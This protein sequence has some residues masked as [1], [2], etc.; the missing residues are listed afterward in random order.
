MRKSPRKR[1]RCY[2]AGTF[3]DGSPYPYF[4]AEYRQRPQ[5]RHLYSPSY[6]I[7]LPHVLVNRIPCPACVAAGRCGKNKSPICLRVLGWPKSPCR[8]VD[9]EKNIYIVGHRYRCVQ[10]DCKKTYQS[11][12]PSLL[13][14]LPPAL[15]LQ[16][17]HRLT[18]RGGLTDRVATLMRS[19]FQQGT[20]P[21]PFAEMLQTFHYRHYD[22]LHL[23]Y[24]QM[25]KIRKES[26]IFKLMG[27]LPA[28]GLFNDRNGYAG[29]VPS[30]LYFCMFYERF[31]D[32]H[33][34]EM[35]QHMSMLTARILSIDHSHKVYTS[36]QPIC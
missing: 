7:W 6:F 31:M 29:F 22:N 28:F 18:Y 11:W 30:P 13:R 9:I 24:L 33:A 36:V 34:E 4:A 27:Q 32:Q 8:V 5:P 2:E 14:V 1:P 20:G 16:F 10:D 19:C 21:T 15:A 25:V 3:V 23:Q 26:P 12:S 35:D 17:T